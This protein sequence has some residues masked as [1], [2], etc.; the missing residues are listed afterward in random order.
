MDNTG[1]LPKFRNN[2]PI[3]AKEREWHLQQKT[4]LDVPLVSQLC[5]VKMNS[6]YLQSV[7]RWYGTRGFL[8]L[9]GGVVAL[10][11]LY[12]SLD[13]IWLVAGG[14]VPNENGLWQVI[15]AGAAAFALL[16]VLGAWIA[17]KELFRWTYYPIMLDRRRRMV[18]VFR[19]DGTTLSVPWDEVFFTLGRGQSLANILNWDVRGLVLDQDR[20]TVKETFAFSIVTGSVDNAKGHW[21]F[22]RR[23]MEEGPA[24]V[25]G[26]VKFCMPV[27]GKRESAAFA[28]ER[29]FANDA[30][31]P[32][33]M[34]L[35]LMPLNFLHSLTRMLVM[36]TSRI[37]A[38]PESVMSTVTV[39]AGDL[40]VRDASINPQDL[41]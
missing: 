35:I 5:V 39:D 12:F 17:R 28:R 15:F 18:H 1:L 41:R 22:L 10:L 20:T 23:Y 8:T 30:Q 24:A 2:R 40:Y 14:I 38:W 4:R 11:C 33:L 3:S 29:I 32:G 36:R 7:D 19:L 9:L 21:E 31:M 34:Y 13:L 37:P 27:D 16:A 25:T 26:A 6:T